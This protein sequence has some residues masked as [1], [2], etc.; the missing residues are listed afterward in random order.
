MIWMP[1]SCACAVRMYQLCQSVRRWRNSSCLTRTKSKNP[2]VNW[3]FTKNRECEHVTKS[4]I[5][6]CYNASAGGIPCF[7]DHCQVAEEAGDAIE[8]Y[9]PI[10]EVITDKVNAE[11][12]ST[13]DGVMGEIL[14]QEGQTVNVGE[15]ICRIAVASGQGQIL[16]PSRSQ[17][18]P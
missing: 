8:Q 18:L 13:L 7:G 1:R 6:R 16:L 12:P 4:E 5:D 17:V 2:C 9:E 10:C 14:A 15:I 3:R 11:I